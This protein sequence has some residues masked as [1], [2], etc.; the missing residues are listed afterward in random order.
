MKV[1]KTL[2]KQKFAI[3]LHTLILPDIPHTLQV[4]TRTHLDTDD[5]LHT[6]TPGVQ[7]TQ[8]IVSVT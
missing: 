2:L 7:H 8:G 5:T 1:N 4:Q 3:I 6:P